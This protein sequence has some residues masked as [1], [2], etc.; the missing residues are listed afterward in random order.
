MAMGMTIEQF[1]DE[2]PILATVFR[3]AHR[4]R[5]KMDNE[6]AWI[7]GLYVYDALAVCLSNAFSKRGA[8]KQNYTEHPFDL[9]PLTEVEKKRREQEEY[10]KMDVVLKKMQQQQRNMKKGD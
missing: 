3:E 5:R 2:P 9:F 7:Q 1:W 4:L 6:T 10:K 8:K